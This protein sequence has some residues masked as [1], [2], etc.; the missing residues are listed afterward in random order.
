MWNVWF[1][2]PLQIYNLLVMTSKYHSVIRTNMKR[3]RL[4][5]WL[6]TCIVYNK[7]NIVFTKVSLIVPDSHLLLKAIL[8]IS[9]VVCPWPRL[10]MIHVQ[11][12]AAN[13]QLQLQR[14]SAAYRALTQRA[15]RACLYQRVG[16]LS[17]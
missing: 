10:C 12:S 16:R 1:C 7:N 13:D 5:N 2:Y 8:S 17:M 15:H 9:A 4:K 3:W 14:A 11:A 6:S